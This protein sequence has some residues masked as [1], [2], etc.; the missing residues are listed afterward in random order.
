MILGS[1]AGI[2]SNVLAER[3]TNEVEEK[4]RATAAEWTALSRTNPADRD[5][6]EKS[7]AVI[8]GDLKLNKPPIV[9]CDSIGQLVL[10]H[11][12]IALL[13]LEEPVVSPS[14][15]ERLN[16][17][18]KEPF[19]QSTL[20]QI[21]VQTHA[22]QHLPHCIPNELK[23]NMEQLYGRDRTGAATS[24]RAAVVSST[25]KTLEKEFGLPVKL[26]VR[27]H[28]VDELH[29]ALPLVR[30]R[31][32]GL[33]RRNRRELFNVAPAIALGKQVD[34]ET[35]KVLQS[36]VWQFPT[37]GIP[38]SD[39]V[40]PLFPLLNETINLLLFED[41]TPACAFLMENFPVQVDQLQKDVVLSWLHL[42]RNLVDIQFFEQI[43]FVCE[44]PVSAAVNAR[45]QL[46]ATD[47]AAMVFRDGFKVYSI[48]GVLVPQS[49]I[50]APGEITI[51]QIENEQNIEVRR[52]MIARYGIEKYLNDSN[53]V[54]IDSDQYG[55]LYKKTNRS[56]EPL[57]VVRV[58]NPTPELDGTHNEYFLRVPPF[59]VSARAAVAWTFTLEAEQYELAFES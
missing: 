14:I 57:V 8:Y 53:A 36:I 38:R 1:L 48:D 42:K 44:Y 31:G 7:V 29:T 23:G 27:Q 51:E 30:T 47:S 16:N 34:S 56:D 39:D 45:G 46:H 24:R 13:K 9:W 12:I 5:V 59:M 11:G 37:N 41:G 21:Q 10:M 19:W 50:E 54:V 15:F 28:L 6:V 2:S 40:A 25:G 33:L 49:S 43:C 17:Q 35:L 26:A 32:M 20:N 18:L 4:M 22:W 55:T 3:M 58:R 52:I